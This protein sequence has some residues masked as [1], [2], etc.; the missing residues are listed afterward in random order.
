MKLKKTYLIFGMLFSIL[1]TFY[2]CNS[3]GKIDNAQ[4]LLNQES[5][6]VNK[7]ELDS[8]ATILYHDKKGNFWFASEEKG[9]FR[10]RAN[11]SK[12]F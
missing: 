4:I 11:A 5:N 1:T 9:V 8:K 12:I 3:Q 7:T 2:S 6:I 10:Y